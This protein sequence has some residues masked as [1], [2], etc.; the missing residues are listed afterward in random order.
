MVVV[1]FCIWGFVS[2]LGS[3]LL[4][5]EWLSTPALQ[6]AKAEALHDDGHDWRP[7]RVDDVDCWF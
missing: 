4:I 7:R 5:C 1:L 6:P 2:L 3:A